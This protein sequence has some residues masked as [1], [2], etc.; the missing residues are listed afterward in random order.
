MV[1][2]W[3]KTLLLVGEALLE[4]PGNP[5]SARRKAWAGISDISDP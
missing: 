4:R 3:N 2:K 1:S 5:T